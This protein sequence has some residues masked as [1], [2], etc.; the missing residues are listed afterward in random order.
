[1]I[2]KS[3]ESDRLH[4]YGLMYRIVQYLFLL[5]FAI[6]F[7]LISGGNLI[8]LVVQLLRS[9]S[10]TAPNVLDYLGRFLFPGI[11]SCLVTMVANLQPEIRISSEGL[12]IRAFFF[13][14]MF[15]PWEEVHGIKR[16]IS[17]PSSRSYL[18]NVAHL[19]FI[20][21]LNGWTF[22]HVFEPAF[23]I[24]P[25]LTGYDEVVSIIEERAARLKAARH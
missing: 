12:R 10:T 3:Q 14:W 21:R 7:L 5:P 22:G 18:V 11:A 13:W 20:H 24:R 1:M 9:I 15:I 25:S 16:P 17:I 6:A 23:L 2:S 19:T 8:A 4:T